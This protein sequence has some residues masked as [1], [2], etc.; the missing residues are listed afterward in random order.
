MKIKR[1]HR[2]FVVSKDRLRDVVGS[3]TYFD[4]F[5][6]LMKDRLT[7]LVT[8]SKEQ[9][10]GCVYSKI[11]SINASEYK[12]G[13]LSQF[14]RTLFHISV[15]SLTSSILLSIITLSLS[16]G[17]IINLSSYRQ[18]SIR[19]PVPIFKPQSIITTSVHISTGA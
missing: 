6:G 2:V 7:R 19:L 18:I 10:D 14:T 8:Q 12:T 13:L 5:D 16:L 1:K 11:V 17:V 3:V 15:S 4:L 9:I